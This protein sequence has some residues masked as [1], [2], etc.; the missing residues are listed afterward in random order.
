MA[1]TNNFPIFSVFCFTR[2]FLISLPYIFAGILTLS[3]CSTCPCPCSP[4]G[5]WDVAI[6]RLTLL[7][8]FLTGVFSAGTI[9]TVRFSL[10]PRA[11][12]GGVVLPLF[13]L[14]PLL[15][16]QVRPV[17]PYNF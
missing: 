13:L 2:S 7:M 3:G 10:A 14:L 17:S 5:G 15:S 9:L 16:H 8:V 6:S 1:F 11:C 4:E 12:C